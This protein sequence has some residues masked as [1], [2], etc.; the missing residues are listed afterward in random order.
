MGSYFFCDI[1]TT[2]VHAYLSL[3]QD[4]YVLVKYALLILSIVFLIACPNQNNKNIDNAI[5]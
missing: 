3:G 5:I 4:M 1:K 2:C